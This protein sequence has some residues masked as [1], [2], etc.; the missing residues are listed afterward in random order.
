MCMCVCVGAHNM[1]PIPLPVK[2]IYHRIMKERFSHGLA[3][4]CREIN[5]L[6]L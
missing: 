2:A 1:R 5:N 4:N 3:E 6:L